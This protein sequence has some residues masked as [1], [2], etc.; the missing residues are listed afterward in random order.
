MLTLAREQYA[1]VLLGN[2]RALGAGEKAFEVATHGAPAS[3][4][5]RPYPERSRRMIQTRIQDRLDTEQRARVAS[6]LQAH[7][8]AD[9]FMP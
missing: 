7:E 8:L 3:Y 9:C 5:A 1:P 2:A 4:L 6:W